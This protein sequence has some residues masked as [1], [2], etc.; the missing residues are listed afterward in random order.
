MPNPE[1]VKSWAVT[2]RHL[3]ACRYYLPEL[4][5]IGEARAI[6]REFAHYLH[7]NEFGL[8]LDEADALGELCSAPGAFWKELQLAARSMNMLEEEKLYAKRSDS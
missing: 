1:P 2:L 8:A 3:A 6:E 5:P 7:H 4:L